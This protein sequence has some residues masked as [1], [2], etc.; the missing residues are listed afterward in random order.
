MVRGEILTWSERRVSVSSIMTTDERLHDIAVPYI[1]KGVLYRDEW[2]YTKIGKL[3]PSLVGHLFLNDGE[4]VL[5]SAFFSNES[6]YAFTTRRIVS[7]FRSVVQEIDPACGVRADFPNPKGC[8]P[9][10][11]SCVG[12]IPRDIA[13]ITSRDSGVAIQ[14][15]YETWEASSLP[16]KAVQFWEVKYPVLE[17]LMTTLEARR[18]TENKDR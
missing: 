14:F 13:T 17:K 5:V 10:D 16:S 2:P 18:Y 12:V 9:D 11:C 7:K 8:P 6:W 1:L 4:Q 15:E 3:H